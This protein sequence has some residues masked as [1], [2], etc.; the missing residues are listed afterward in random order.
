MR[1]LDAQAIPENVSGHLASGEHLR[2]WSVGLE[3]STLRQ[4]ALG[5]L[6]AMAVIAAS[7]GEMLGSL[8]LVLLVL[9]LLPFLLPSHYVVLLTT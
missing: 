8:L 9:L 7:S 3:I 4:A 2:H 6:I 5:A 1:S